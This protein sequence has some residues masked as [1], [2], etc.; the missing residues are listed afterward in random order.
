LYSA[1]VQL[2]TEAVIYVD[3]VLCS[4]MYSETKKNQ[5]K[6]AMDSVRSEAGGGLVCLRAC[7]PVIALLVVLEFGCPLIPVPKSLLGPIRA[8][9]VSGH[10]KHEG[11]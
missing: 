9:P 1:R 7:G 10:S 11:K 8:V 5:R 2:G 6:P 3:Y 4:N